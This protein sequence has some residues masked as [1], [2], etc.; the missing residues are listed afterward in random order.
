MIAFCLAAKEQIIVI[1]PEPTSVT[2][3]YA[4]LK[5]LSNNGLRKPPFILLNRV[6]QQF[7]HVT[8]MER[9]AGV[10]KKHLQT[11]ILPLGSIPDDPMFRRAAAKSVLPMI[12]APQ[13]QG[14][15]ALSRIAVR[16][17]KR[18]MS[19]ALRSNPREFWEESLAAMFR[20]LDLPVRQH[21]QPDGGNRDG[22]KELAKRLGRVEKELEL[23][24]EHGKKIAL[25]SPAEH[26][27]LARCLAQAGSRLMALAEGITPDKGHGALRPLTRS[28]NHNHIAP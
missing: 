28:A 5:V 26:E 11:A 12:L 2:D 27:R 19:E 24:V 13:A 22:V 23:I 15:L 16:L 14:C 21:G 9:F 1:N 18:K 20:G 6:P 17:G 8:L 10:C 3:G 25:S 7:D 4:L